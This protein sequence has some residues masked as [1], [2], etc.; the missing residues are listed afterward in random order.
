MDSDG[1]RDLKHLS[2]KCE[3]HESSHSHLDNTMRL[4][5]C[6]DEGYRSGMLFCFVESS[7]SFFFQYILS[8]SSTGFHLQWRNTNVHIKRTSSHKEN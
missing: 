8:L 3:R 1:V 2:E 4:H 6:S 5:V 7:L